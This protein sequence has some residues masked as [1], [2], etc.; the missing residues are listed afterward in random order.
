MKVNIKS[1]ALYN[2]V[3]KFKIKITTGGILHTVANGS[4]DHV[5]YSA[6]IST[7]VICGP[8]STI[9]SSGVLASDNYY[10]NQ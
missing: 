5:T 6:E 10:A 4:P 3:K 2:H 7:Y 8:D 9:L 1:S